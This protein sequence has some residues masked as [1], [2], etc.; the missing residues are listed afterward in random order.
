MQT[1]QSE[2]DCGA[3]VLA[4]TN[5]QRFCAA[6]FSRHLLQTLRTIQDGTNH[7]QISCQIH[8]LLQR[9]QFSAVSA[10]REAGKLLKEKKIGQ[11]E[12]GKWR[13]FSL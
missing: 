9:R 4:R 2:E 1:F 7:V 8:V 3:E 11:K 6:C 10:H 13:K 5:E 12:I